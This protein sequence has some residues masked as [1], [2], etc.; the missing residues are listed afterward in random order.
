[1]AT[2]IPAAQQRLF[3]NIFVCKKCKTK[4]RADPRKIIERKILSINNQRAKLH[5]RH[6]LNYLFTELQRDIFFLID[7][8]DYKR[9]TI[10][11][12]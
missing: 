7:N 3:K 11:K 10:S 1:M 4:I 9:K 8:P 12:S 2:K 6:R 5:K